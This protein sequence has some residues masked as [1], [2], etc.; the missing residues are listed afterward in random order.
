ME[1]LTK[2]IMGH[3]KHTYKMH[4]DDQVQ[5]RPYTHVSYCE[6]QKSNRFRPRLHGQ[7]FE[8]TNCLPEQPVN[9]EPCKFCY[10]FTRVKRN[11]NFKVYLM[12]RK[13]K[14]LHTLVQAFF[15]CASIVLTKMNK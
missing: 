3:S 2:C 12:S 5:T 9:K 10:M 7:I 14:S 1:G 11:T 8:R 6:R 4:V 15:C 13:L